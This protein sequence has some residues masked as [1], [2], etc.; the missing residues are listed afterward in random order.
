MKKAILLLFS[1]VFAAS[2]SLAQDQS[3]SGTVT[4]A[5]DG[6]PLPGVTVLVSGTTIGTST[7]IDGQYLLNVP[8]DYNTLE[9]SFVGYRTQ[10]VEIAGRTT[11]NIALEEDVQLLDDVVVTAL[12]RERERRSLAYTIQSIDSEDIRTSGGRDVVASLQG[13][14]AGL[15]ITPGSGLPGASS[16]MRIRGANSL[17]GN[18]APL[19]VIDGVP[20]ASGAVD[21][22][23]VFGVDAPNRI[24]DLNPNDIES[25]SV[26][27]GSSA[28]VL[29]GTRASNGAVIITTRGGGTAPENQVSVDLSTN[30]GFDVV[31][32]TPDLQSTYA[33]GSGGQYQSFGSFSWGPRIEDLP[34]TIID[35]RGEEVPAPA[36]AIDNVSPFF[37]T[38]ITSDSNIDIRGANPNGNYSVGIGYVTQEGIVPTTGMDRATFRLGGEYLLSEDLRIG[39]RANYSNTS[40]D[41]IRQ[42]SDLS[43]PLFTLYWAPRSFDL[44]N[45]PFAEE[46][47]PYSQINYRG[48]MDNPRWSLENNESTD[49][50]DRFFGNLFF[51]YEAADWLNINY[52]IGADYFNNRRKQVLDLGSGQTG[53]AGQIT[54]FNRYRSEITSYLNF[55]MQHAFTPDISVR[56]M[57]GNEINHFEQ[58]TEQIIGSG[59]SIGGFRNLSNA[60]IINADEA[61][62]RSLVVGVYGDLELNYRSMVLLNFSARNDWSST[63][64]VD[65]NSFFYPSVGATFVFTEAL[66]IPE[67]ILS[68]GSLKAS[69]AQVGQAAPIYGTVGTYSTFNAGSG[70][71]SDGITFPFSGVTGLGLSNQLPG[72]DLEPQ[73]NTTYELGTELSFFNDRVNLEYTWYREDAIN[74]IFSV[75]TASSSGYTSHLRNAGELRNT[76]H[77]V[78]LNVLPVQTQN[79]RWDLTVNYAKNT[80]EVIELAPGVSNI[81]L[82][83]FVDPNIRAMEGFS[84]PIIFGS[85]Y[86]RDDAGNIVYNSDPDSPNYG[87]A[88]IDSDLQSVGD[89]SPD[90]T[91]SISNSLN[92]RNVGL[93]FMFDIRQGGD[94][95]SGNTR[96]Q[97]LYGMDAMTE[98]RETPTNP[99]GSMGYFDDSGELVVEGPNNIDILKDENYWLHEDLITESNVYDTSFIRLRQITLSYNMTRESV[100]WLPVN[101]AEF[102]FTGRNLLLFTDYPN[103]DPETNLG[104]DSNFQGLEYVNLPGTRSYQFGIRVSI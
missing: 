46:D 59:L 4:D 17:T 33:Q 13:R 30:L 103:W 28:A 66:D 19:F 51:D 89:V 99:G 93:S 77:E 104:G 15:E 86:V 36:S 18:N 26:L 58:K 47:D 60:A 39:G 1:M 71:L 14:V 90:W 2:V 53:G 22:G 69:W 100:S 27:K 95:W 43:N 34:S 49:D 44:W 79:F 54:E 75:P 25:V 23:N 81:F 78:M 38:G 37:Q 63:L 10:E 32:R 83:G 3:I 70:F 80:S 97:K 6:S 96:L 91:G 45:T 24:M 73:N 41:Q 31:S 35:P 20:V 11:I 72:I 84:Y 40:L 65:N 52:R 102:F 74:Q 21:G 76:G 56:A 12:G 62:L 94:M 92:Y 85:A 68:Y 82:G 42:G 101:N 61:F 88:L 55:E 9:I 67:S 57:I 16:A 98:D 64:P 7:D 48:A 87:Y 50:T 29:Y 5:G 8:Q